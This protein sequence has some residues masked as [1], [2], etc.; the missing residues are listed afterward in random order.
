VSVPERVDPRPFLGRVGTRRVALGA[1]GVAVLAASTSAILIRAGDAPEPVMAFYRVLFTT[2]LLLPLARGA[3]SQLARVSR[4]D[5]LGAFLAGVALAA[6]FAAWFESV[7][8]TTVA[9]SVTLVQTQ[10]VFVAAG[11]GLVLSERVGRRTLAG[12]AVALLGAGG[13]SA[14]GAFDGGGGPEPLLGNALALVGAAMAAVYVLSG[15]SIRQRVPVVPYVLVVYAI[16]AAGL[17][18]VVLASGEALMGYPPREWL[19]F[20]GMAVGPG[21]LGHTLINWA[22]EH[23]ES[24]VVSVSLV[25]EPVGSTVL[26]AILFGEVP[27]TLALAAGAVV[28]VGIVVTARDRR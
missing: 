22:L 18:A 24:S 19:L 2:L 13:M 20:L 4:R 6:H 11:A 3:G 28:I 1:V 27:G 7:D 5:L 15:R 25:G 16:A 9:A 12:I 14:A 21:L 26:A 23:V 10:T 17:L 8:R